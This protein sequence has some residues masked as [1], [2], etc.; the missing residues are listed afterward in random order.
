MDPETQA[1]SEK[2][3]DVGWRHSAVLCKIFGVARRHH[4][5]AALAVTA[6]RNTMACPTTMQLANDA[7]P[8]RRCPFGRFRTPC[9]HDGAIRGGRALNSDPI[10]AQRMLVYMD[11]LS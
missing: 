4:R 3:L 6:G 7:A 5:L 2:F 9:E 1:S 11:S 10:A 8:L